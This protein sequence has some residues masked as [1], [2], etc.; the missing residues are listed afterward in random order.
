MR[1]AGRTRPYTARALAPAGHREGPDPQSQRG[2]PARGG[3]RGRQA[4]RGASMSRP[5]TGK[6]TLDERGHFQVISVRGSFIVHQ[7]HKPGTER[8]ARRREGERLRAPGKGDRGKR[9][10][11]FAPGE[12]Q[13]FEACPAGGRHD[14]EPPA[15]QPQPATIRPRPLCAARCRRPQE[16]QSGC[17]T[18]GHQAGDRARGKPA[19]ERISP[20][21]Q[22]PRGAEDQV[23]ELDFESGLF[24][25]YDLC[26]KRT[27]CLRGFH[28][29]ACGLRPGRGA[30]IGVG[31]SP[32]CIP[33]SGP[34]SASRASGPASPGSPPLGPAPRTPAP[35]L[36]RAP[37]FFARGKASRRESFPDPFGRNRPGAFAGG[38]R[39]HS[40]QK[41]I[42]PGKRLRQVECSR[43]VA[44]GPVR[45]MAF[46]LL[47][48][49]RPGSGPVLTKK[50]R[51]E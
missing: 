14:G 16:G 48:A 33:P 31:G 19:G 9:G 26:W 28:H 12:A 43:W 30:W 35:R 22:T 10:R 29:P 37:V 41:N 46:R 47:L 4:S 24:S 20:A 51:R 50:T 34:A 32:S 5:G 17:R 7:G 18:R 21:R 13:P 27:A 15:P 42:R 44:P 36:S 2:H 3:G 1:Q 11:G 6:S 8:G 25:I 45:S 39:P 23:R 40:A 38:M 49:F